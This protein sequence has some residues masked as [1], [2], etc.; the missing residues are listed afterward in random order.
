MAEQYEGLDE[1]ALN[2][3]V[4]LSNVVQYTFSCIS[5]ASN[6]FVYFKPRSNKIL[7]LKQANC[8]SYDTLRVY[9]Y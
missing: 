9:F 6:L 3:L 4:S 7:F 1:A 5:S 2:E 8:A